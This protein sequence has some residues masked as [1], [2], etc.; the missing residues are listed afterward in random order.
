MHEVA[1]VLSGRKARGVDERQ[2]PVG[3]E[4]ITVCRILGDLCLDV[5]HGLLG[6]GLGK[7][8]I[9]NRWSHLITS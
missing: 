4:G 3:L 5:G 9:V 2:R 6:D 1:V 7:G 8:G